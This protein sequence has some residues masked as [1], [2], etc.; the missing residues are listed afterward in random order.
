M[1]YTRTVSY[2]Q[3]EAVARVK[4]ALKENKWGVLSDMDVKA[5][6]KEKTGAE[7]ES[8][9]ILD[10]CNPVLAEKA[11][12]L[13]KKA[14]LVLPCKMA[15][16]SDGGKTNVG[17]YLPTRMLPA[18]MARRSELLE[19]ATEAEGSLKRIMDSLPE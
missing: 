5:I 8:Y 12:R 2:A 15:V 6:L 13:N 4:G 19:L 17:L 1:D 16:F 18:E 10:V 3:P 11:L 7:I 9:N 14:G